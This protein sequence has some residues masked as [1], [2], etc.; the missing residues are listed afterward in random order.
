MLVE[1]N[2][3][4]GTWRKERKVKDGYTPQDEQPVYQSKAIMVRE[5]LKDSRVRVS[6]RLFMHVMFVRHK[7]LVTLSMS[8]PNF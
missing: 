7:N 1:L 6:I 3:P 4:D 8:A 5:G 2:R